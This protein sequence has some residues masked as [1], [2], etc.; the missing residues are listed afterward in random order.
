[1]KNRR[2][3]RLFFSFF[4]IVLLVLILMSA[5]SL[6]NVKKAELPEISKSQGEDELEP[7][8]PSLIP[9]TDLEVNGTYSLCGSLGK[10]AA[11][12][13]AGLYFILR[14]K[15]FFWDYS[16]KLSLE[17]ADLD[18]RNG[19]YYFF[20]K[21]ANWSS[22]PG[23]TVLWKRYLPSSSLVLYHDRLYYAQE[24]SSSSGETSYQL[25][26]LNLQ[27][28]DAKNEFELPEEIAKFF[29]MDGGKTLLYQVQPQ[30]QDQKNAA[31]VSR[32]YYWSRD[33]KAPS[34]LSE[35][36]FPY[37]FYCNETQC[38]FS[39]L[40]KDEDLSTFLQPYMLYTWDVQSKEIKKEK[41]KTGDSHF[42]PQGDH[43]VSCNA[44][45]GLEGQPE[46][47]YCYD[48][49]RRIT[50]CAPDVDQRKG[51]AWFYGA[52]ENFTYV[53]EI[54]DFSIDASEQTYKYT[55]YD[56]SGKDVRHFSFTLPDPHSYGEGCVGPYIFFT[57]HFAQE[58]NTNFYL[59]DVTA[60][61]IEAIPLLPEDYF[62]SVER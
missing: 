5:C 52:S 41:V 21:H 32:L 53:S 11:G 50:I 56:S 1:M 54:K 48:D 13:A 42:W 2:S 34:L 59:L 45:K 46:I 47:E 40:S 3:C 31:D 4:C 60:E 23:E 61:K 17:L 25:V 27:G 20:G 14:G 57:R 10:H 24:T 28:Q 37:S 22:K 36:L 58:E 43:L 7:S 29:L 33:E 15:L 55:I 9:G 39:A 8:A 6:D 12:C 49:L 44:R 19:Q 16:Q 18:T 35:T 26:S 62:E 51:G 38:F 30:Q